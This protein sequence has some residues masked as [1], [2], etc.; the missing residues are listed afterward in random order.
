MD[1]LPHGLKIALGG[2]G[3]ALQLLVG[4]SL[5]VE[6]RQSPGEGAAGAEERPAEVD[7]SFGRDSVELCEALWGGRRV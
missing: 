5:W 1:R 4:C 6:R 7:G 2:T 3:D